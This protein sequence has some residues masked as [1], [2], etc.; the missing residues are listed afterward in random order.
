MSTAPPGNLAPAAEWTKDR[1][2]WEDTAKVES[3][4]PDATQ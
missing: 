2:R 1:T 4:P 3:P